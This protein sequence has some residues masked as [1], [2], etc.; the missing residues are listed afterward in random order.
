MNFIAVVF[1]LTDKGHTEVTV[2]ARRNKINVVKYGQN[3]TS[4]DLW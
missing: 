2:I 4:L 1:W 3:L